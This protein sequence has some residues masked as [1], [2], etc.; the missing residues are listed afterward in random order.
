MKVTQIRSFSVQDEGGRAYMIVR[1]D[2][3]AGHHGLGEVGI[4]NWG[5]AINEAINHLAELVIG[6]DP[7][8]TE[9]LWQEMFRSGFFPADR[10]YTCAISAIDIALWDIKGKSVDMPVYKLLG[11]PVRNKVVCY[12]HTQGKTIDELVANSVAAVEAGWKFVRWGQPETGG[13]FEG[14]GISTLEPVE[15]MRIAVDQMGRV[16]EAV[17]PDIQITF[18]VHT[19]LDTAHVVQMCRDLEEFK[20]F[21]IEDPIRSENQ[22]SYRN[23]RRQVNLPIAA[24]EQWATKW[25]FREVIEEDLIDYARID[26]CIVGGLTEALKITHWAETH[27]IDIV[28][29]NPLGPVSAAACVA[30]CMASTNVGVQEMPRRPGSYATELFPQQLGWADGY[31]WCLDAPGLGVEFDIEAAE[32]AAVD[33]HGWPPR[34]RRNDGAL[35]NW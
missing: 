24:G 9:R 8:E 26:L 35:T 5:R 4:R 17:G 16:R 31:S 19:R 7:W 3:D 22:G 13:E 11:G 29:H 28:P 18:D 20:P 2:T 23:L 32:H 12:P 25:S 34:L 21:F 14:S 27:Y 15:S 10:V 33:P 6:A 30:L 1:V